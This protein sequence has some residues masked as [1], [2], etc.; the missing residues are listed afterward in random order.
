[1]PSYPNHHQ[2]RYTAS[3]LPISTSLLLPI[4]GCR[5][6][7]PCGPF[8]VFLDYVDHWEGHSDATYASG[9]EV[10]VIV[11]CPQADI[12]DKV[13]T[14]L[15]QRG[16]RRVTVDLQGLS[17]EHSQCPNR[18]PDFSSMF[19]L[20]KPRVPVNSPH[21]PCGVEDSISSLASAPGKELDL[22]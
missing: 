22:H 7:L 9:D 10:L 15:L 19:P 11:Q 16:E 6:P 8:A 21:L 3:Y 5:I 2:Q 20:P 13:Q 17:A 4:L 1:M 18:S 12:V 14:S